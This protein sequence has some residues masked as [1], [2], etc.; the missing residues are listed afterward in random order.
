MNFYFRPLFLNC[1]SFGMP[2]LIVFAVAFQ[3][4]ITLEGVGVVDGTHRSK[5]AKLLFSQGP[6]FSFLVLSFLIPCLRSI[7][8]IS[9]VLQPFF[10]AP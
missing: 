4:M 10:E 1:F 9:Q 2:E 6:L 8:E 7:C 5:G 3:G